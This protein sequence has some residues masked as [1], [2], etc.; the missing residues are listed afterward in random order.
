MSP[1][2]LQGHTNA[3]FQSTAKV[4]LLKRLQDPYAVP[5]RPTRWGLV[6]DKKM[7]VADSGDGPDNGN[8]LTQTAAGDTEP[9]QAVLLK[10]K[11]IDDIKLS[12]PP[13]DSGHP[14]QSEWYNTS[15]LITEET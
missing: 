12:G 6:D 10:R 15:R 4:P 5:G 13:D 2:P 7:R 1:S 8:N 14:G 11:K 9:A 3:A